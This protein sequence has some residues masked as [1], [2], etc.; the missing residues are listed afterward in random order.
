[1]QEFT[2]RIELE[3]GYYI[4]RTEWFEAGWGVKGEALYYSPDNELLYIEKYGNQEKD[5]EKEDYNG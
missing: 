1:M 2:S 4:I 5:Y 3:D